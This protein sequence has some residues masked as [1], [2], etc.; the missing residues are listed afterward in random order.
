MSVTLDA[1]ALLALLFRE[2]G[3]EV[4]DDHLTGACI[5]TVNLCE[6]LGRLARDGVATGPLLDALARTAV[7]LVPFDISHA[8]VAA[9]MV[10]HV[11]AHRLSPADRAWLAVADAVGVRAQCIR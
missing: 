5:S 7:V 9:A 1:S 3:W 2:P 6:V 11:R 8:E 4:V 10:P